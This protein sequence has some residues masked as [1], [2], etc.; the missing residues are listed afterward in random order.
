VDF[1]STRQTTLAAQ[2]FLT[3]NVH[4]AWF[5]SLNPVLAR[6]PC[7]QFLAAKLADKF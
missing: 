6:L 1:Q 3:K 5:F 7:Q 2:H 4:D